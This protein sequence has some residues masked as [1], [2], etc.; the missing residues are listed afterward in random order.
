MLLRKK[1]QNPK[2]QPRHGCDGRLKAKIS[3]TTIQ[4]NLVPVKRGESNTNS[5]ELSS[6]QFLPLAYHSWGP[7]TIFTA[8]LFWVRLEYHD[9]LTTVDKR[10]SVSLHNSLAFTQIPLYYCKGFL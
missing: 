9:L 7:H 2:W 6:L 1:M 10:S 3:I 4:V 8:G 5:P